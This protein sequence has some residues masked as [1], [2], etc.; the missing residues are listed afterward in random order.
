MIDIKILE[1][2]LIT[3]GLAGAS[4]QEIVR[5]VYPNES[6][7][8]ISNVLKASPDIISMP[9]QKFVHADC[10]VDIDEAK[11]KI[12]KILRTH[13]IQFG[14][15][16]NKQLLFEA[17][18]QEISMFLNDNECKSIDAVYS[19]AQYFFDKRRHN[20][21]FTMN[22]P[23]KNY[24]FTSP[25]IFEDEPNYPMT[26][27]GL[28]IH[29]A[30][31]NNGILNINDAN[32]FLEKTRLAIRKARQ[33]TQS[34]GRLL[35]IA[36]SDTFLMYNNE[37]Y[38]LSEAIGINDAW[39]HQMHD[40]ID[41]LFSKANV[42]YVIPR[43]INTAWLNTLP[44]TPN[45]LNWT[46]LLLQEVLN[47]FPAIG[48][49][50]ISADITQTYHTL[51]A[52]FTPIASPLQSFPD[53]VTLFMEGK[54]SLPKRMSLKELW[55]DLKNAGMLENEELKKAL[56]RALHDYRFAWTDENRYVY[57]RGNK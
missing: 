43:D 17:A 15:Y 31:S 39:C 47:K 20:N 23:T 34:L 55:L 2:Y 27:K 26:I 48:F 56:P 1:D 36:T 8:S 18:S 21:L 28:M 6:P 3:S 33:T 57:V 51:S 22:A 24:I 42:A 50:S 5:D 13:F 54:Y 4:V 46:P 53:V 38:L 44:P 35:Q 10:Y 30:R 52:A 41:D 49:K 12:D 14:G 16:S 32:S 9:L 25:H 37:L 11:E 19:I 7:T 40:R 29:L 45:G